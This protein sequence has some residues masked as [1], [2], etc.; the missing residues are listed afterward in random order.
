MTMRPVAVDLEPHGLPQDQP[1]RHLL[2]LVLLG[3]G[4]RIA[5]ICRA[6]STKAATV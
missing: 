5:M 1:L 3:G 6:I 4:G 2:A